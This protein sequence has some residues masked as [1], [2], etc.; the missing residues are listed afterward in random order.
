[1]VLGR[2][3]FESCLW[4]F[5]AARPG[6]SHSGPVSSPITVQGFW[7]LDLRSFWVKLPQSTWAP[8]PHH[9]HSTYTDFHLVFLITKT[10]KHIWDLIG[11]A[12]RRKERLRQKKKES[13]AVHILM[14]NRATCPMENT[15]HTAETDK[16]GAAVQTW[17]ASWSLI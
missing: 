4:L 13:S 7:E 1:M 14:G 10:R 5:L 8:G 11:E 16:Q 12:E 3:G 15:Q 2:S 17:R 9:K 6:P